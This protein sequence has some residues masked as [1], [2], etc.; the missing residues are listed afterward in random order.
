MSGKKPDRGRMIPGCHC[1]EREQCQNRERIESGPNLTVL[2][3]TCVPGVAKW[4]L[5][6]VPSVD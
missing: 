3:L 5:A 2:K 4:T 6:L 1:H